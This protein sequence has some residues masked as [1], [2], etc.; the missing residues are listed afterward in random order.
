MKIVERSVIGIFTL[1]V[2]FAAIAAINRLFETA[3]WKPLAAADWA[4]WFGAIGT[5]LAFGGTIWIAT[6]ETR[7]RERGELQIAQFHAAAAVLPLIR[8]RNT[9]IYLYDTLENVAVYPET[10]EEKKLRVRDMLVGITLPTLAELS[11]MVALPDS[12]AAKMAAARG[13]IDHAIDFLEKLEQGILEPAAADP[14][15]FAKSLRSLCGRALNLVVVG[16]AAGRDARRDL[17]LIAP[18]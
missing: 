12:A 16:I 17:G 10:W 18:E 13:Q 2:L 9:L 15:N 5:F 11:L 8:A 1:V 7:R 14:L 3:G 6:S 4:A